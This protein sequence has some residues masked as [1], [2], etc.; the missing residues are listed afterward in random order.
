MMRRIFRTW[1]ALLLCAALSLLCAAAGP[2]QAAPPPDQEKH[3]AELARAFEAQLNLAA[4]DQ[5]L[6]VSF[7]RAGETWLAAARNL[8]AGLDDKQAGAFLDR[9]E[10]DY[11]LRT[12]GA[13]SQ[14][15]LQLGGLNLMYQSLNTMAYALARRNGDK[16]AME[17]VRN[18]EERIMKVVGGPEGTSALAALSGGVLTMMAVT[19]SQTDLPEELNQALSREFSLRREVD[20]NISA[21]DDLN[22]VERI[23]LLTIN[24][25]NGTL[26]MIQV[27]ALAADDSLLEPMRAIESGLVE[28][29][30]ADLETQ[31][32]A[33]AKAVARAGFLTVPALTDIPLPQVKEPSRSND[34]AAP[35]DIS[36]K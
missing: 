22:P 25:L 19:A 6:G 13:V 24:H 30:D 8:A 36:S 16:Q 14:L 7:T 5:V 9:A 12:A 26:S 20:V 32:L 35:A 11:H 21:R 3:I 1:P 18:T 15:R 27:L 33:A 29:R 28:V 31:I 17:A 34:P 4:N 10:K 2:L 23:L